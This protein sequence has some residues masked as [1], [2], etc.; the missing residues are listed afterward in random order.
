MSLFDSNNEDV[1]SRLEGTLDVVAND[2]SCSFTGLRIKNQGNYTVSVNVSIQSE[3]QSGTTLQDFES[4]WFSVNSSIT[5]ISLDVNDTVDAYKSLSQVLTVYGD[6]D[7]EFLDGYSVVLSVSDGSN[8]GGLIDYFDVFNTTFE[9]DFYLVTSG[10]VVLTVEVAANDGN[11][12]QYQD[13][14]LTVNSGVF[15]IETINVRST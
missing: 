5:R 2:S 10:S 11:S 13:Y 14:N 9:L 6:N 3:S 7:Q 1:S 8:I 12:I 15:V 4:D